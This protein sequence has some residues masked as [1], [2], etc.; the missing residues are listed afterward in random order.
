M[1]ENNV[2]LRCVESSNF[3]EFAHLVDYCWKYVDRHKYSS[4][5]ISAISNV[6]KQRFFQAMT[7]AENQVTVEFDHWTD[8]VGR[9]FLGIL[10]ST[11]NGSRYLD[12]LIEVFLEGYAAVDTVQHL[13]RTLSKLSN[14]TINSI[15]SDS[16]SSCKLTRELI[17][18]TKDYKR[19]IQHRCMAHYYYFAIYLE[20][21][22]ILKRRWDGPQEY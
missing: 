7:K 6:I 15:V 20:K 4:Y 5:L 13:A 9:S 18:E 17:V 14:R 10:F 16:P 22:S 21:K 3:K 11:L 2:S 19:V 8:L 12:D 1:V